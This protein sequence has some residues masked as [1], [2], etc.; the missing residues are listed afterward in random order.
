[1]PSLSW[2]F[3][4]LII[5]LKAYRMVGQIIRNAPIYCPTE[6]V[7][8]WIAINT[9]WHTGRYLLWYYSCKMHELITSNVSILTEKLAPSGKTRNRF[10]RDKTFL[11]LLSSCMSKVVWFE[12]LP[13]AGLPDR[14]SHDRHCPND[15][16]QRTINWSEIL[17]RKNRWLNCVALFK[18]HPLITMADIFNICIA[19]IYDA[20]SFSVRTTKTFNIIVKNWALE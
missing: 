13:I 8:I 9:N 10:R 15:A 7:I 3:W 18:I 17:W 4:L 19:E 1:M 5:Q 12:C 11:K 2:S 16:I 6:H 20:F 14:V